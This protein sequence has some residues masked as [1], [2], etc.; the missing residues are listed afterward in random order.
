MIDQFTRHAESA[1]AIPPPT[2]LIQMPLRRR[3]QSSGIPTN[4]SAQMESTIESEEQPE[5]VKC[6]ALGTV[7]CLQ[8][9]LERQKAE[10][11]SLLDAPK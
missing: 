6:D 7:S 2:K 11:R 3:S 10:L 8:I 9:I 1:E 5:N 4:D